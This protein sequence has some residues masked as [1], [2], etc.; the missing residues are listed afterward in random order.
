[1]FRLNDDWKV[2]DIN[3]AAQVLYKAILHDGF[4]EWIN[5]FV[6]GFQPHARGTSAS[7]D[8]ASLNGDEFKD[9]VTDTVNGYIDS[10]EYGKVNSS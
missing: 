9:A 4:E 5:Q 6:A 1:L 8:D 2:V 7:T 3:L 10:E